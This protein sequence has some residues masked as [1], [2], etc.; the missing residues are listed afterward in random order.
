MWNAW[1]MN[2]TCV[3]AC[4][5]LDYK[6]FQAFL[7][8]VQAWTQVFISQ[9]FPSLCMGNAQALKLLGTTN[10][11]AVLCAKFIKCVEHVYFNGISVPN[12]HC[13]ELEINFREQDYIVNEGDQQ[14]SIVLRFREVQN[15]FTMTLHPVNITEAR[16]PAGFDV[17]AF[18]PA[19]PADAQAM[20]GKGVLPSQSLLT[21]KFMG[22]GMKKHV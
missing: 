6:R 20:P 17:S 22:S 18:I 15:S 10:F 3:Q 12:V 4:M 19:V 11:F 16:D 21:R 5:H 1:E 9:V 8:G 7:R 13:T 14:G 2:N